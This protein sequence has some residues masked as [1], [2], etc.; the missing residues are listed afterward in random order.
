MTLPT[1]NSARRSICAA[2]A[3]LAAVLS[4][5][6]S[7]ADPEWKVGLAQVKITPDRPVP[8]SGYAS[9]NK[10]SEGVTAD[11]YAKALVLEDRDGHK[12]VIVTSDLLGFP[13]SVAE[14]ICERIEKKTGM[15]REQILLNSSHNHSGPTV[16]LKARAKDGPG[17][18]ERAVEY[19]RGLQDKVVDLVAKAMEHL[20]PARLSWGSGVVDFVMN[21]REFTPN[22]VI[23]GVN[24]RG[25]A[26]RT[27]P[28]LR[29]D[30]ADGKPLTI[31]FGA[32]THN[33][34]LG[35]DN[36]QICGD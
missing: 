13:A 32:G 15:K 17:E 30:S 29:V 31:L 14:P 34:T 4:G 6:A 22:G 5:P 2:F 10:L 3:C 9:R 8:M 11:L 27:V 19:T 7:A 26:D 25:L 36:Y 20:V 28:V 18:S 23:L 35:G 21:R 1:L 24:P 16:T 12:A 33:T